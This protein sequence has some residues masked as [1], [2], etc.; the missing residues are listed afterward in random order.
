MPEYC[1]LEEVRNA[2]AHH[3]NR[4]ADAIAMSL[5]PSRGLKV[6]GFEIKISRSDWTRE[7]KDPAKADAFIRY[8]DHWYIAAL[9]GIVR[10]DELPQLWGLMELQ[11]EKM[12]VIKE[13]P[14]LEAGPLDRTFVAAMMR[15]VGERDALAV[16][17]TYRKELDEAIAREARRKDS[18]IKA[19]TSQY[20][21]V[22]ENLRKLR[23]ETGID[24]THGWS[25][26]EGLI[27]GIQFAQQSGV[28]ARYHGLADASKRMSEALARLNKALEGVQL[29]TE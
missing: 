21:A 1:L 19:A 4:S 8:C 3:A 28:T 7:L 17:A 12:K 20:N 13:A 26:I 22:I 15:R 10:A 2:A 6:I 11:G 29:E 5:W 23:E 27:A 18:E 24:L 14:L 9:P 16:R 25:D